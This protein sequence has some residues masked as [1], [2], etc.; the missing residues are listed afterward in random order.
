M[1][2]TAK[3]SWVPSQQAKWLGFK[4]DLQ[5]GVISVP[6]EKIKALKLELSRVTAKGALRARELA[7]IIGKIIAMSLAL[8]SLS[9]LM[10]RH[11]M[12]R[13][14]YALLNSRDYW[15]QLLEISPEAKIELEFWIKQVEHINGK[16]IW[17][18]PS[19]VCVVYSD[20]SGTCYGGF[21]VEHGCHVAHG[22]WSEDQAA[23]SSTWR[24]LK[25]VRMVLESLISR[26][27]NERIR[28]F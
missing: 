8:G 4:L 28:W 21:T 27:K 2:H 7:S 22:V 26:L 16:E 18:S 14:L 5:Q 24:E 6:D 9:R 11:L 19:A 13:R 1:E 3:C 17:H 12:T 20:A 15:Y 23:K 25:A 10:T